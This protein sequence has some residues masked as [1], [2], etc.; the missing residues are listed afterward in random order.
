MRL[1]C[2]K[3]SHVYNSLK[4]EGCNFTYNPPEGVSEDQCKALHVFRNGACTVS[5]HELTDIPQRVER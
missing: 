2:G 1:S 3:G 4:F 5:A